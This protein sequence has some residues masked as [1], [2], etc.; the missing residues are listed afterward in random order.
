MF[1]LQKHTI[2]RK[3]SIIICIISDVTFRQS[4]KVARDDFYS[5]SYKTNRAQKSNKFL[6]LRFEIM[7]PIVSK[8]YPSKTLTKNI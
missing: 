7:Y 8:L 4:K 1:M 3:Q 5:T 6:E 2:Y